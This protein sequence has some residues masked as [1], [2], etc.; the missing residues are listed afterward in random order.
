MKTLP[1]GFLDL[2][3]KPSPC[4]LTTLMPDGSPQTTMT[5][6]DTDGEHVV[7]N[8]VDT[9][10]KMK[11]IRRDPRVS[12]AVCDPANL[13]NYYAIRGRVVKMTTEGAVEHVDVVSRKYTG[14]PYAWYGGRD[15]VRV[16]LTIVADSIHIRAR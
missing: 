11:N 13:A 8:T 2:L 5:W 9:H 1:D 16:L 3:R 4:F 15:Q 14:G 6:V 7:I 10:L 12:V